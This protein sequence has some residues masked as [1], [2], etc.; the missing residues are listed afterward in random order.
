MPVSKHEHE[1]QAHHDDHGHTHRSSHLPI[2]NHTSHEAAQLQPT[3]VAIP[4]L[5][6]DCMSETSQ[7]EEEPTIRPSQDPGL[8]LATVMK[9]LK[10]ELKETKR[11]LALHQQAYTRQDPT[12]A[13]RKRHQLREA[14]A[15]LMRSVETQADR[16]YALQD[17]LEGQKAAG[18]AM[19]P[20]ELEETL[21]SIGIDC[22]VSALS[23][24]EN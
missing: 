15:A 7:Y 13:K 10:S 3:N 20:E 24:G 12:L 21:Q 19:S 1:N 8:A 14:I 18:Q 2:N 11:E 23:L 6:S 4:D 9:G 5:D 17:V 22:D 16:I